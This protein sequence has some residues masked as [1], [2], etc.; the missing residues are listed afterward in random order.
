M[1]R[2]VSGAVNVP[3]EALC[4]HT[5]HEL[6]PLDAL[7]PLLTLLGV[8]RDDQVIMYCGV[9]DRSGPT[10]FA[11]HELLGWPDVRCYAGAWAEYGSLSDVLVESGGGR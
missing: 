7:H 3:I 9:A 11:L 5:T 2:R 1:L 4:D 10:W 8:V 6:L